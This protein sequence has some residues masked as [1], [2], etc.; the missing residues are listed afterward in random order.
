MIAAKTKKAAAKSRAKNAKAAK[1]VKTVVKEPVVPAVAADIEEEFEVFAEAFKAN[2][3]PDVDITDL[4]TIK[5]NNEVM[6]FEHETKYDRK[7]NHV[8]GFIQEA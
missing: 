4:Q 5:E 8:T 6:R 7:Q 3:A 2:A 1:Q